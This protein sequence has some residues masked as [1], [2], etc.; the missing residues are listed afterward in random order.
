MFVIM[1]WSILQKRVS[2]LAQKSFI[3]DLYYNTLQIHNL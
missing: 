2:T 3:G 1:K